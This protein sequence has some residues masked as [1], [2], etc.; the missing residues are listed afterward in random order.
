MIPTIIAQNFEREFKTIM[1]I[2]RKCTSHFNYIRSGL[3]EKLPPI[4]C[5]ANALFHQV[6]PRLS[7]LSNKLTTDSEKSISVYKLDIIYNKHE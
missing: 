2:I 1:S 7:I 6:S 3:E 5:D 4:K